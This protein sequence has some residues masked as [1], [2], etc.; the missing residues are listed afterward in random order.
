MTELRVAA[1]ALGDISLK[2]P[3]YLEKMK[4]ARVE[5][6]Q[7]HPFGCDHEGVLVRLCHSEE[8]SAQAL[9]GGPAR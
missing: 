2:H 3:G 7:P 4:R 8:S 5:Y 6:E 9:I 1:N